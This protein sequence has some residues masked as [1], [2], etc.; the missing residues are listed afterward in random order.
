MILIQAMTELDH[1]I[2]RNY[3]HLRP[4]TGYI[5]ID[6][7][8]R[9]WIM[10]MT[11]SSYCWLLGPFSHQYPQIS[12][13]VR[14]IKYL[15]SLPPKILSYLDYDV[16]IISDNLSLKQTVAHD[17]IQMWSLGPIWTVQVYF[18]IVSPSVLTN[19]PWTLLWLLLRFKYF[20]MTTYGPGVTHWRN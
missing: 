2:C 9:Q 1:F 6:D 16:A 18:Q 10:L 7:G 13:N 19:D 5:D 11:S 20:R 15:N 3:T 8:C 12:V 14:H 4:K 17:I